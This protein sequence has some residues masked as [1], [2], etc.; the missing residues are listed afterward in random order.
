M[1]KWISAALI[2]IVGMACLATTASAVFTNNVNNSIFYLNFENA[3]NSDGQ[4]V[5]LLGQGFNDGDH[6][7]GIMDIQN[8]TALGTDSW[9][10]ST[11][12][13]D[14]ITGIFVQKVVNTYATD[15][16]DGN[17]T[18][19]DHILLGA[20]DATF[21]TNFDAVNGTNISSMLSGDE[22]FALYRDIGGTAFTSGGTVASG[23]AAATDGTKFMT[24]G[25]SDNGTAPAF[26]DLDVA[27]L[28]DDDGYFYSHAALSNPLINLTGEAF[29]GLQVIDNG[30]A[31]DFVGDVNDVN[32]NEMDLLLGGILNDI[33]MTSE[34]EANQESF[35]VDPVNGF[36][37]WAFA[38]NDPARLH[39]VPEPST[40]LLLGA[41]LI[42]FAAYRRKQNK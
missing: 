14:Q 26:G 30:I 20:P 38:S 29:G 31:G 41:G 6:L 22:M 9:N 4:L 10:K 27:D 18:A 33:V 21:L 11:N 42:G 35:L 34:F 1:K 16:I 23:I 25:Y 32:E 37:P 13:V 39:P 36:S 24:L 2:G 17:Q 40:M 12:P 28:L 7:V 3:Y 8:I 5:D 15:P 19:F